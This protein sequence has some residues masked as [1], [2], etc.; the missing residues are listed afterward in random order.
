MDE[1]A[2]Y[3]VL[4]AFVSGLCRAT[5]SRTLLRSPWADSRLAI[6]SL[7]VHCTRFAGSRV[8]LPSLAHTLP[9]NLCPSAESSAAGTAAVRRPDRARTL[10][11]NALHNDPK[12]TRHAAALSC[13][14][15]RLLCLPLSA[16][17][18]RISR[19]LGIG[20]HLVLGLALWRA[21]RANRLL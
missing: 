5:P 16:N 10:S 19:R 18:R 20:G 14:A 21:G 6:L 4:S 15:F 17:A 13:Y 3:I 1:T 12:R 11:P 9:L 8:V 2:L 7:T